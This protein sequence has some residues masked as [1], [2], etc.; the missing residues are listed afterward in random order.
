MTLQSKKNWI[1]PNAVPDE[2]LQGVYSSFTSQ[3]SQLLFNRGLE[4]ADKIETF[5]NPSLM[6]VPNFTELYDVQGACDLLANA[7]AND[8]KIYIHGDFDVDGVCATALLWE[9]LFNELPKK[10]D[11]KIDVV[12]YIPDRVD[13]GYGLSE[14]SIQAMIEGGA[15][16]IISVDCGIRDKVLIQK[17]QNKNGLKFI[18]TDHHQP[19]EDIL[20]N[21]DYVVV[22]QM[23]PGHEYPFQQVCGAFVAFQFVQGLRSKFEMDSTIT[24]DTP[25]LDLVALATIADMMPL[26][27]VNRAIVLA[28]LKQ[29]NESKRYGL[30]SLVNAAGVKNGLVDSYHLGYV[31]GPRINAAGRIGSAI[32]ALRLMVTDSQKNADFYSQKLNKLNFERQSL[33]TTALNLARTQALELIKE[34]SK[35]IFVVLENVHEGIVGLVAGKLQEEF[36]RPIIVVTQNRGETR[37]SARSIKGFNITDA[38]GNFAEL[39]IKYGGHSQA[40]GFTVK[41]GSLEEFKKQ[42]LELANSQIDENSLVQDW[43]IDLV[44]KVEDIDMTLFENIKQFQPFGYGNRKPNLLISDAVVIEKKLLGATKNHMKLK[45]KDDS[46]G[47]GEVIMFNVDEDVPII[48]VDDVLSFV[49]TIDINEWNGNIDVQFLVKEWKK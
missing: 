4:Q 21:L 39:L 25:G 26:I 43:A 27:E 42:L 29:I 45:I 28:G 1:L 23:Y 15:K 5:L 41:E 2:L 49:G 6:Q 48:N 11:K 8:E 40:A 9:F 33:T 14:S 3:Q 24:E 13:E 16:V 20:E 47:I 12:P 32:D 38:I 19:P 17:Y 30:R 10:I 36:G 7:I 44:V 35:L 34:K 22:H 37:G 18:I 31:V 46:F